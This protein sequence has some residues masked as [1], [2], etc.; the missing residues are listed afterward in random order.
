[1]LGLVVNLTNFT[2]LIN[3]LSITYEKVCIYTSYTQYFFMC[4]SSIVFL[5]YVYIK[6][7][8]KNTVYNK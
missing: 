5:F 3:R 4:L 6:D 8:S 7:E 2:V 1:M